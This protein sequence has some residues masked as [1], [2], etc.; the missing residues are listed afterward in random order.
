M[1]CISQS[2]SQQRYPPGP[3]SC[4]LQLLDEPLNLKQSVAEAG[5]AIDSPVHPNDQR[6]RQNSLPPLH[7]PLFRLRLILWGVL[8]TVT[9][10]PFY[11]N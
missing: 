1:L 5:P 6:A 3:R 8:Y 7:R 11:W 9:V 4:P 2:D 10:H